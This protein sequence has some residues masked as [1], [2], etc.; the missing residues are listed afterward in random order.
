MQQP[1][2]GAPIRIVLDAMGGDYA[3]R[4]T[5]KGA[6]E[7]LDKHDVEITLVGDQAAVEAELARNDPAG[8]PIKVIPSTGKIGDDEHRT[9]EGLCETI[10]TR[11][12]PCGKRGM[13]PSWLQPNC[14]RAARPTRWCR[15]D[16]PGRRWPAR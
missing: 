1:A 10:T 3:P 8:L 2:G 15:W 4:E 12:M 5:V 16:R 9:L 7:A 11:F 13:P 6:V 14:S